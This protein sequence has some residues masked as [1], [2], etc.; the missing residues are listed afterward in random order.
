MTMCA[1]MCARLPSQWRYPTVQSTHR[2]TTTG[3]PGVLH[4]TLG[5]SRSRGR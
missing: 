2:S 5:R 1:S 4:R 3:R